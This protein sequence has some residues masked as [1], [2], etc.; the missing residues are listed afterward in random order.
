MRTKSFLMLL[1]SSILFASCTKPTPVIS[2]KKVFVPVPCKVNL[3][4][5]PEFKGDFESAREIF[6]YL[7]VMERT[8]RKCNA[9]N[10]K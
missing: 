7:E 4:E 2:Y 5:R 10:D 3:P 8:L 6:E 9:N 1:I